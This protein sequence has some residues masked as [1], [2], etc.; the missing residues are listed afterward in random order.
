MAIFGRKRT[1]DAVIDWVGRAAEAALPV[2][3]AALLAGHG[4]GTVRRVDR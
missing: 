4:G 3:F 1:F 2:A